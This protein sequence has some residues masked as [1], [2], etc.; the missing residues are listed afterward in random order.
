M[1]GVS[2]PME[3]AFGEIPMPDSVPAIGALH[4]SSTDTVQVS[5]VHRWRMRWC[6]DVCLHPGPGAESQYMGGT[7]RVGRIA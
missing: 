4:L 7:N 6:L 5:R 3:A 2:D 1:E